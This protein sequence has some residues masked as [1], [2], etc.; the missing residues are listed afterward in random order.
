MPINVVGSTSGFTENKMD[1]HLI[2]QKPFSR[3][4]YNESHIEEDVDLKNQIKIKN[5]PNP[6]SIKEAASKN[7]VDNLVTDP[8]LKKTQQTRS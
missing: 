1:T 7:F 5:L 6:I 2:V 3:T 4:K 8:R